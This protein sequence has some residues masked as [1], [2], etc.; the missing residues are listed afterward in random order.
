MDLKQSQI[1][2]IGKL[3]D[4]K[5]DILKRIRKYNRLCD[6][7]ITMWNTTANIHVIVG[8]EDKYLSKADMK[9]IKRYVMDK[10]IVQL[11]NIDLELLR[12]KTLIGYNEIEKNKIKQ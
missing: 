11:T 2:V 7:S 6:L 12:Y 1:N 8:K 3:R 4:R 5:A 10:M 9:F